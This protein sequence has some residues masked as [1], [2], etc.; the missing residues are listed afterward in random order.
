MLGMARIDGWLQALSSFW[1]TREFSAGVT[2]GLELGFVLVL[3]ALGL[4]WALGRRRRQCRFLRLEAEGGSLTV[5]A[6]ALREFLQRIV[7][8]FREIE[9]LG[10]SLE[11]RRLLTDIRLRVNAVPLASLRQIKDS[12]KERVRAEISDKLGLDELLGEVHID[13]VRYSA[14]EARIARRM[15]KTRRGG[16]EAAPRRTAVVSAPYHSAAG[17]MPPGAHESSP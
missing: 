10:V 12:L 2:C 7:A 16:G 15:A 11:R 17:Y 5:T 8:D 1:W 3:V 6:Q 9:L 13:V 14:D 4:V